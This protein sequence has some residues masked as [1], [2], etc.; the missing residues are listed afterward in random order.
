MKGEGGGGGKEMSTERGCRGE[1]VRAGV[2]GLEGGHKDNKK[3]RARK[4]SLFTGLMTEGA[5]AGPV[6][7]L[8]QR[9]PPLPEPHSPRAMLV[10]GS[11]KSPREAR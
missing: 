9:R 6:Q 2:T 4:R 10:A 7:T 11:A 5:V 8:A 1:C 3:C